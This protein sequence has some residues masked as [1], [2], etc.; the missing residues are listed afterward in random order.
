MEMDRA[1]NATGRPLRYRRDA[2]DMLRTA[3]LVE[4]DHWVTEVSVSRRALEYDLS[5]AMN[6]AF[7][8]AMCADGQAWSGMSMEILT[9]RCGWSLEQVA[10][11]DVCIPAALARL[12]GACSFDM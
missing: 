4:L 3:G 5:V 9:T 2:G 12:N 7:K 8:C 6:R 1:S 11:L 10:E